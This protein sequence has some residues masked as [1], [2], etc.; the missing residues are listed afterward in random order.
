MKSDREIII[1]KFISGMSAGAIFRELKHHGICRSYV[2]RT[3]NRY[4]ET[5]SN[6]NRPKCGRKRTIRTDGTIKIVRER[7]R[8]NC[9]RSARKMA[10]ELKINRESLRKILKEDLNMIAFKKKKFMDLQPLQKK[11]GSIEVN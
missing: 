3:I 8:R 5:G 2:Y 9:D 1:K 7:I 11:N 10:A 6:E 4:N